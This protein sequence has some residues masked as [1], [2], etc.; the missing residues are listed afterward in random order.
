MHEIT[1]NGAVYHL[2]D[3]AV[4]ALQAAKHAKAAE[5]AFNQ[6]ADDVPPKHRLGVWQAVDSIT[7]PT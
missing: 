3:Y 1:V 5:A 6:Y 4:I 7:V 2:T